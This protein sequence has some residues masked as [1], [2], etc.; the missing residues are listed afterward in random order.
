MSG[1]FLSPTQWY[2]F[3]IFLEIHVSSHLQVQDESE[4]VHM[5]IEGTIQR[6]SNKE[7]GEVERSFD[8]VRTFHNFFLVVPILNQCCYG[9]HVENRLTQNQ[10]V[11][12]AQRF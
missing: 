9:D 4:F 3:C 2:H 12:G 5:T 8:P 7:V 11:M 10:Y 1:W 6:E